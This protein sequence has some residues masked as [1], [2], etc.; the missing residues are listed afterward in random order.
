MALF[1]EMTGGFLYKSEKDP[2]EYQPRA[3]LVQPPA[4]G[5]QLPPPVD[6]AAAA[7]PDWPVDPDQRLASTDARANDDNPYNDVNQ[8]EYRRLRPLAG[9]FPDRPRQPAFDESGKQEYYDNIVHGRRQRQEFQQALADAKGFGRKE[10]RFL[11]D[12]PLAYR[13]PEATAPTTL[14]DDSKE[15]KGN[16]F[17]RWWRGR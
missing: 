8:A 17:T 15:S 5:A 4:A 6:A 2:I 10:R 3:P 9:V 7:T 1:R 13:E 12:P 16:F 11:T 14:E